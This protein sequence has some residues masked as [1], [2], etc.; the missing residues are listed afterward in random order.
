MGKPTVAVQA[1]SS[2]NYFF[3]KTV[4]GKINHDIINEELGSYIETIADGYHMI[5]EAMRAKI[6][7]EIKD[8]EYFADLPLEE[9]E[10]EFIQ[11]IKRLTGEAYPGVAHFYTNLVGTARIQ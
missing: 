2:M 4:T 8:G 9:V 6:M 7:K 3:L 5:D 1:T 11:T 10:Q